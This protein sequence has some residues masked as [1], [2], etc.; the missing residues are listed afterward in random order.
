MSHDAL[1][2][3]FVQKFICDTNKILLLAVISEIFA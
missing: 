1:N 2:V 3:N